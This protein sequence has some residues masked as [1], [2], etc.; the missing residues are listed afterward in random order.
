V[1]CEIL[2]V[3]AGLCGLHAANRLQAAGRS[4]VVLEKSR[5]L[6][7]RAATRRWHDDPVDHG[8]QFFTAKSPE[9]AAQVAQWEASGL[10]HVWTHGFHRFASG[11][12]IPPAGDA[13]PR[14]ACR[15]G[16]S[17]LGRALG[18]QLGHAVHREGKVT[19]IAVID[20][21]WQATLE[22]GRLFRARGLLLTPPPAQSSALLSGVAPEAAADV[23]RHGSWPCL[24]LAARF[25]RTDLA[26]QGIQAPDDEVLTWIGHDTGKRP[27]LHPGCTILI[28]HAAP[29]FSQDHAGAP[30]EE[31]AERLLRRAAE[32]TSHDWTSPA[33]LFLHRWRYA[34]PVPG[35]P[36]RGPAVYRAPA[37]LVVAGDWCGGGRI[38]G[39]WLAGREAAE[40]LLALLD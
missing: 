36:R 16:M 9:F 40:D 29:G 31:I 4:V 32:M 13:R 18:E 2:I 33:E 34:L 23:A 38:E 6:G 7:G 21:R 26:W 5:G 10:C 8:A 15:A 14:Y 35:A 28:L 1:S 27:D 20:G 39:A 11:T 25:P 12:L 3:G 30:E 24:A 22:D 17:S 37:P 19:D